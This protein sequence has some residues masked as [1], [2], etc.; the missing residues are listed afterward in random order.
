MNRL[1]PAALVLFALLFP[2]V[3]AF[4][5]GYRFGHRD[6]VADALATFVVLPCEP[7]PRPSRLRLHSGPSESPT[8]QARAGASASRTRD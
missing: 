6:G 4:F 5:W 3:S 7:G 1:A 2:T 8:V